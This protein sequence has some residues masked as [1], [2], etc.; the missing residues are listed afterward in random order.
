MQELHNSPLVSL[1]IPLYRSSQ[2]IDRIIANIDAV[3][4]LNVE[5]IVSDRHQL[6]DCIHV[7]KKRYQTDSRIVFTTGDDA[8][9]FTRHI[10]FLLDMARGKYFR[11]MPHDDEFPVCQL[12][13]MVQKLEESPD[14]TLVYGPTKRIFT[15]VKQFGVGFLVPKRPEWS[16]KSTLRLID[17]GYHLHAFKGLIRMEP[18]RKRNFVLPTSK[19]V[20]NP[21][22]S[23]LLGLLLLG[24]FAYLPALVY[25]KHIH[26]SSTSIARR[27]RRRKI[28]MIVQLW[29][30]LKVQ[31]R[32]DHNPRHLL[33]A[34]YISPYI[35]KA[36]MRRIK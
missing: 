18:I 36:L 14:H 1:A 19:Y 29:V 20:I 27:K 26:S 13:E 7:L 16:H 34:L 17:K 21:E 22:R 15:D 24:P 9:G 12:S 8:I 33:Y 35:L 31:F 11:L 32:L 28:D 4:Y 23:W 5:I 10:N 2:F 3:R 30:I 25:H 6:D